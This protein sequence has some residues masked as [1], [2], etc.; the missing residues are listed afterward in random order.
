MATRRTIR[1]FS[2]RPA[3]R[4]V[5]AEAVATDATVPEAALRKKEMAE[6]ASWFLDG[7]SLGF[8]SLPLCRCVSVMNS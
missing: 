5:I 6:I 8:P 4:E 2:E 1:Q 3:P 7:H